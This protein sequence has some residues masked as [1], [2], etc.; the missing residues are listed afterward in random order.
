MSTVSVSQL[1]IKM[2]SFH[3]APYSALIVLMPEI[4]DLAFVE[5]FEHA[6]DF[7]RNSDIRNQL[8]R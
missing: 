6:L 4:S 7:S 8:M 2:P 3:I 1:S 5:R